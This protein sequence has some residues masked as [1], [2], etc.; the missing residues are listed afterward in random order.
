MAR[1]GIKTMPEKEQMLQFGCTVNTMYQTVAMFSDLLGRRFLLR[2]SPDETPC[3]D[4]KRFI[5]INWESPNRY[6]DEEHELA[7]LVFESDIDAINIF[8]DRM[9]E[10]LKVKYAANV[11]AD[12]IMNLT[13]VIEDIRVNSLWERLYFGSG[14]G[15]RKEIGEYLDEPNRKKADTLSAYL[16]GVY[17][18]RNMSP[19][20]WD[21]MSDIINKTVETVRGGTFKA[22]LMM[23]RK[24]LIEMAK[25]M[26]GDNTAPP[27]QKGD[28][29]PSSGTGDARGNAGDNDKSGPQPGDNKAGKGV[30]NSDPSTGA[31]SP[32]SALTPGDLRQ[33]PKITKDTFTA[34]A[35]MPQGP[36]AKAEYKKSRDMALRATVGPATWD[37][38]TDS[39]ADDIINSIQ[40]SITAY[41][42]DEA[43]RKNVKA[44]VRLHDAISLDPVELSTEQL[45]VVTRLRAIVRQIEG[46]KRHA[47]DVGGRVIDM[48]AHMQN[49]LRKR[50]GVLEREPEFRIDVPKSGFTALL[51]LDASY[52]MGGRMDIVM[53]A[54]EIA[55]QSM[56]DPTVDLFVWLFTSKKHGELNITRTENRVGLPTDT[57]NLFGTTPLH[58][59]VAAALGFLGEKKGTRRLFC[60][61]DGQPFYVLAGRDRPFHTGSMYKYASES[62]AAARDTG[63]LS[64]GLVLGDVVRDEH[65]TTVFQGLQFWRR[66]SNP[67]DV[68][69]KLTDLVMSSYID[70]KRR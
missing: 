57:S 54:A 29:Q 28:P 63:I 16:F 23:T 10:E 47:A 21:E 36:T 68:C 25:R 4:C 65:M 48:Q 2:D 50:V 14:Q 37:H 42:E 66:A 26:K 3:T 24:M 13:N 33:V 49:R 59:A 8:I 61:T 5:Y 30:G 39:D 19:S 15:M 52:S 32:G 6:L 18:G 12:S 9:Q 22:T 34:S 27:P 53:E 41:K 44:V 45:A 55:R 11:P 51:L 43:M 62:V 70:Y 1:R 60:F 35:T 40:V 58:L 46:K 69:G 7:H 56:D 17:I 31:P 38:G 64:Y 20:K 67:E